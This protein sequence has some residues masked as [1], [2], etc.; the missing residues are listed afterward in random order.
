MKKIL[1]AAMTLVL[2][3]FASCSNDDLQLENNNELKVNF[4]VA[5]KA[6]FDADTRAVKT[7]WEDGDQIL[8]A[9]QGSDDV[10]CTAD[11]PYNYIMLT[12]NGTTW[13]TDISHLN[14][15]RL[16]AS[17]DLTAIYHPGTI[18]IGDYSSETNYYLSG[19][20]G[21]EYL[22]HFHVYEY[23]SSTGTLNLG[24]IKLF[25][26]P[27]NFQI[28][29][30]NLASENK[31][32]GTWKLYIRKSNDSNRAYNMNCAA[33]GFT[34][35]RYDGVAPLNTQYSTGINYK[36]DVLFYF[37]NIGCNES[38]LLFKLTDDTDTYTYT[39]TTIPVGKKAYSLPA[40]SEWTKK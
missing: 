12:Y 16:G 21:G 33:A 26:L 20:K 22:Y 40:L 25:R 6:G 38:S 23:D 14:K 19:Y 30:K 31:A 34:L 27:E 5:D 36:G 39:T 8:I 29:I 7:G 9:L 2:A 18:T 28:S 11:L 15:S 37:K 17:G 1:I 35:L 13:T 4:S 32:D 3:V 10:W 24:T